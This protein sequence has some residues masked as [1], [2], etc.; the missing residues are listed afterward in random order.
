MARILVVDDEYAVRLP[1]RRALESEGHDVTEAIHGDEALRLFGE[2]PFDLVLLDILMPERDG[3]STLGELLNKSPQAKVIVISGK[4]NFLPE[5]R[6]LG[7]VQT[8]WKPIGTATL[9]DTVHRVLD[10]T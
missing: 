5:A 7:A 1:L 4:A 10:K 9:L 2:S 3:L 6:N 8:L